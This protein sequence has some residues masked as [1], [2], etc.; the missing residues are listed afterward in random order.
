MNALEIH[1]SEIIRVI[2]ILVDA[3]DYL[4]AAVL[5][6]LKPQ[7]KKTKKT[8]VKDQDDNKSPPDLSVA[9]DEKIETK[10]RIS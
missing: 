10:E 5:N 6:F 2:D 7:D 3:V 4:V 8:A 9:V 1:V